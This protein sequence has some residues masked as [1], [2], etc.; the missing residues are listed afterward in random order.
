MKKSVVKITDAENQHLN[1]DEVDWE[2]KQ[3]VTREEVKTTKDM[4]HLT[5]EQAEEV[6][7]FIKTFSMLLYNLFLSGKKKPSEKDAKVISLHR[8]KKN[9]KAA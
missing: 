1:R 4:E 2:R 8:K 5:D 7:S 6:T 3:D 9:K